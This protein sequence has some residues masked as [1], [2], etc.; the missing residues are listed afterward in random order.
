MGNRNQ[1]SLG[2]RRKLE[3]V[4]GD[5][6]K[7][8]RALME[9]SLE[10]L[11]DQL[12]GIRHGLITTAVIDSVRVSVYGSSMPIEHIARTTSQD[13]RIRIEPH[14][15]QN[16][17]AIEKALKAANFEAFVFSKTEVVVSIPPPSGEDRQKVAARVQQLG[18]ET[19]VAVRNI[20]KKFRQRLKKDW[21]LTK[22]VLGEDEERRILDDLQKMTDDYIR[23]IDSIVE[24]K[25]Q[26]MKP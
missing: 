9:K 19:R 10:F 21:P 6:L 16:R 23:E 14:D 17:F 18:E 1:L 24:S 12:I 15:P 2:N 22:L 4:T 7:E 20:R 3:C 11:T 26:R 25:V 13:R 5:D 8:P